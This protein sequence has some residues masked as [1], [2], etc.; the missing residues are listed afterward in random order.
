M[1]VQ[2]EGFSLER[3]EDDVLYR[4]NGRNLDTESLPVPDLEL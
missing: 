2:T 3:L 4:M 1:N